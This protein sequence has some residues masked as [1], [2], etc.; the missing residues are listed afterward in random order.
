MAQPHDDQVMVTLRG[1]LCRWTWVNG[2]KSKD[3]DLKRT[4]R[5]NKN[6]SSSMACFRMAKTY[7]VS[8]LIV[9]MGCSHFHQL[10]VLD[11]IYF[12]TPPNLQW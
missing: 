7:R 11:I 5:V 9:N 2:T 12:H 8:K 1:T 10:G 6:Q 4:G 3:P